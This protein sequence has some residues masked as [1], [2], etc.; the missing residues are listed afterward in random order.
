MGKDSI[1]CVRALQTD[2]TTQILSSSIDGSLRVYDLRM[3]QLN[4]FHLPDPIP[5][6]DTSHDRKCIVLHSLNGGIYLLEKELGTVLK[7]YSDC[8]AAGT[9]ALECSLLSNDEYVI[10]GSEDGK[11]VFYD[12]VGG[13]MVQILEGH[14]KATCS[15]C[16]CPKK[17][18]SS[19]V[20]SGSFDGEGIVWCNPQQLFEIEKNI[21]YS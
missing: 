7:C 21:Y 12:L 4:V 1:S 20:V 6:F 3:G 17:G 18:L 19:L 15:V 14:R 9:Y 13:E 16:A 8:H 2:S 5:F 11:V 10:S